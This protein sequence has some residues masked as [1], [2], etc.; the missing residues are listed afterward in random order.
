MTWELPEER[1]EF[2]DAY[3]GWQWKLIVSEFDEWLRREIK[4]SDKNEYEPVREKL[5]ELVDD[6]GLR[7]WG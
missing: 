6:E 5:R 1:S 4:Y 2:M 3:R 7:I